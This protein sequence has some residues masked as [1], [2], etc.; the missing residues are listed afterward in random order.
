MERYPLSI[1]DTS[2]L[3]LLKSDITL[4]LQLFWRRTTDERLRNMIEAADIHL[5][6]FQDGIGGTPIDPTLPP[7]VDPGKVA[8]V[9]DPFLERSERILNGAQ[10]LAAEFAEFKPRS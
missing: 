5:S 8:G 4:A 9:L 7:D 2:K 3:P 10:E 1:L 6:H